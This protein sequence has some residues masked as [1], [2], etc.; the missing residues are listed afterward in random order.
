MSKLY[1]FEMKKLIATISCTI[2]LIFAFILTKN[3]PKSNIEGNEI[4]STEM[5]TSE[6][7]IEDKEVFIVDSIQTKTS[8]IKKDIKIENVNSLSPEQQ[9]VELVNSL[10]KEEKYT[11]LKDQLKQITDQKLKQFDPEKAKQVK[12]FI[13][14]YPLVKNLK[15]AFAELHIDDLEAIKEI[16]SHPVVNELQNLEKEN[17]AKL[18]KAMAN[19]SPLDIPEEKAEAIDLILEQTNEVKSTQ[20]LMKNITEESLYQVLMKRNEKLNIAEARSQAQTI[21]AQTLKLYTDKLHKMTAYTYSSLSKDQLEEFSR[22][23]QKIDA[24]KAT[25]ASMEASEKVIKDFVSKFLLEVL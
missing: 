19:N 23:T 7:N 20:M 15:D 14:N 25:S 11:A 10:I 16:E 12:E 9:K 21:A 6:E 17:Q 4:T 2:I 1:Q 18:E 8:A 5:A 13:D 22:F 24:Q 3:G